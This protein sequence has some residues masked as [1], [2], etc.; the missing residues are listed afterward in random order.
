MDDKTNKL[1]QTKVS[2]YTVSHSG[3]GEEVVDRWAGIVKEQDGNLIWL[4][5][6]LN[7]LWMEEVLRTW[8]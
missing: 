3:P 5:R 8:G 1:L 4:S 2:C 6:F 7:C